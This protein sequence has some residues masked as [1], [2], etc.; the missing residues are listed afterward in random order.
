MKNVL[1]GLFLLIL[2][3]ACS[4]EE[5]QTITPVPFNQVTLTDGFWK[6]RMQTE[7]NVTVP[8]SVEQSAPAVERFRRC[9]A[10][11]AGDSTALPET[12]RFIS[13]DLYKVMEGV[14]Y[15]LMI[16]PNK[17]LEEFM[18][19][20]AD[21]ITASQ[22]DDGYLYI[23][24]ICGNPDPREMGEKPYSWVVHSHELYN[25][26]HLYEAAVAYYQATGKDKLLN[27][28]I[29][30][31]KHVNKVFFEGGDPNYNGGKPIN[32]AP[33]HEEIELALCR[34]FWRSGE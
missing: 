5:P 16:Q 17:E 26:G 14:S 11:L 20:V 34:S 3:T 9:A 28:A 19:R 7:I 21:L 23:S 15:S 1:T 8:F 4:E 13:S 30:S 10:F 32:Q 27:V 25:V 18:D 31:A 33:G 12:H 22:K 24:H 2:A 29:K 6:N